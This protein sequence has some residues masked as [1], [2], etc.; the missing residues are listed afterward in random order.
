MKLELSEQ[1]K[2]STIPV[3]PIMSSLAVKLTK[4]K[5]KQLVNATMENDLVSL[6]KIAKEVGVQQFMFVECLNEKG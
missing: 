5:R 2:L 1:S 6:T 3:L 4:R